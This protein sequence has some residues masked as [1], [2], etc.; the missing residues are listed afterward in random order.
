[1]KTKGLENRDDFRSYATVFFF[2]ALI[3]IAGYFLRQANK[4]RQAQVVESVAAGHVV[5]TVL[6]TNTFSSDDTRV[7]TDKETY[8]VH[9][10][11]QVEKGSSL[12]LEKRLNKQK[13][14]CETSKNEC[15][16]L[17]V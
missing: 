1:M 7:E 4:T 9:G 17:V 13:F 2:V 12:R 15:W 3:V 6:I 11:A 14:L 10:K 16:K 8:L 5:N